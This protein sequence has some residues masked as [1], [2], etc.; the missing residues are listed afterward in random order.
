MFLWRLSVLAA[1]AAIACNEAAVISPA[2]RASLVWG[3]ASAGDRLLLRSYAY[4]QAIAGTVQSEDF[5]Y[6]GNATTNVTAVYATEIGATQYASAWLVSGGPG[7]RNATLR[8]QSSAGYG[9]YYLIDMWG[10]TY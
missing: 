7:H 1:L 9:Y 6:R 4:K 10:R 8:V 2:V 5:V 3:S